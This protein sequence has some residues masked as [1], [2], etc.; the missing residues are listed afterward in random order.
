MNDVVSMRVVL[1]AVSMLAASHVAASPGD[2]GVV[3]LMRIV[4]DPVAHDGQIVHVMGF[5]SVG[6][7]VR[8]FV[9]E[10]LALI[11]P[12]ENAVELAISFPD[13]VEPDLSLY[14]VNSWAYAT[15][16]FR[17]SKAV[18][19]GSPGRIVDPEIACF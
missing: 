14:C 13:D 8:I 19:A 7:A 6:S 12:I 5:V 1:L 18:G 16:T 11:G 9:S 2:P 17:A 3:P 10:E 4:V 15:G